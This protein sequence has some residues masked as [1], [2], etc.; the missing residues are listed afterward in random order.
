MERTPPLS[1]TASRIRPPVFAALQSRI[2]ALAKTGVDTAPFHLG[3]TWRPPPAAAR[4]VLADQSA[5]EDAIYRYGATAGLPSLRAAMAEGHGV[6]PETEVLV[7]NG[8]T[9]A[10]FCAARAVLDPG[11]EV[12]LASPYW[13][14][15]AGIFTSCG[16]TPIDV[17]V[18]QGLYA[19]SLSAH[20]AF[21]AKVTSRTKALYLVSPNNPD[22]KVLSLADLEGIASLA[23][24][25]DLWV[26]SDEVYADTVFEGQHRSIRDLPGMRE[27]T[28][29]LHSL[30]KSRSLAGCRV[31]FCLGPAPAITNARRVSVHSGF[32]TP[33]L[34]QRIAE[35]ALRDRAYAPVSTAIYRKQRDL[36]AEALRGV[37]DFHL[38]DGASYLF[39][40][41]G[42][43]LASRP[44]TSLL[45]VAVDHG[46]LLAPGDAFGAAWSNHARLCYTSVPEERLRAGLD[47]LRSAI[48]TFAS[49][50]I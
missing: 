46:V 9:H 44:L 36:A 34:M 15:S 31:G 8:G 25:H 24:E 43:V 33:V 49:S 39:L 47:R 26:F 7:G 16:A 4:A 45:E 11:D 18:S 3:D 41:F 13:P 12:L 19:G 38:S 30:S 1:E 32:N 28:I 14:L 20:D 27:R 37:V 21:A 29:V 22:G 35:A 40:D 42:N 2:D 5:D 48:T 17:P 50:S 23:I 6:D 10:L